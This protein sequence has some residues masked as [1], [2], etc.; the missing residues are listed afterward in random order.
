MEEAFRAAEAT[1]LARLSEITLAV[2]QKE[3]E[4]AL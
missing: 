2:R 3:P 4:H 1:V